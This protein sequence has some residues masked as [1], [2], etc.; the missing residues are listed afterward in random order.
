M[1]PAYASP[2]QLAGKPLTRRT[3]MWSWGVCV[4]EMIIGYCSWEAGAVAPGILEAY[5]NNM[6]DDEPAL[7]SIP[8]ALSALLTECF[9]EAEGDR[10]ASLND[11]AKT[12]Q[13]IYNN[14][15][16]AAYPRPKP[17]GGS[18]TASSLNNQAISLLD[19]EQTNEAIQIWNSALNIDPQHFETNFNLSLYQWKNDGFEETELLEKIESLLKK[20]KS[21]KEKSKKEKAKKEERSEQAE[22]IKYALATLYIQFGHY[23]QVI[24]MLNNNNKMAHLPAN[25]NND[26]CKVLGLALCA[27]Y[28]LIKNSSRWE[29]VAE[30]LKKAIADTS[31]T[32]K[33]S[34]P[35]LITAYT[36]AL[37]RSGQKKNASEFFKASTAIGIIPKQLKQAVALFLPGYEI[38]Y[39]I[40]KKTIDIVQF[41]NN[42]ENI[43]FNQA[44]SLI[45]WSMKDKQIIR[46]MKG[47][48]AKITAFCISSDEK[49]LISGSEQGDIRVWEI[50]TGEMLNVWSAHKGKINAL[51][52]SSCGQ[53]LYTASSENKLCLWDYH[54]KSRLN[55]FYGEGHS[56]EITDI[57]VS[58]FLQ[59]AG[60]IVSA[61]ADNIL[62]VWDKSSGRTNH[63]LSGHDMAITSVQWLDDKHI[64][65]GSQDKTIRLWDITTGQCQRIYKGHLGMV[66]VLRADVKQGFILSGSSDGAVRFWDITTASSYTISQFSGAVRHI[67]LDASKSFALIVTPSGISMIETSNFFRYHASYLFSLPESAVEVDQLSR[68]YQQKITLAKS[69]LNKN[70]INAMEEIQQARSIK[71]Y[72]R[73]YSAFKHW[74]KLYSFFPKLNLKDIWKHKDLKV[75]QDRIVSLDV[76]PLNDKFYSAGKDHSVYQWDIETQQLNKI[77][78]ELEKS[79][80]AIK[81]TSDGAGLLIACAENILLM[82]INSGKQLSLFSNHQADVIAMAITADGRFVLSSD[83]K[84]HF[85]LWRLLTGEVMADFTDKKNTVTTIVVTPDG[86]F[87]LTGQRNNNS[88]LIWDMTTGKC[89]SELQEHENIVT[90]IAVTSNGRYL[91]SASADA[92]LRLWQVQSSRKKSVRVMTGHT[93]RINQ[94]AIDYQGKI[95]LSVSADKSVRV[96]DIMNGEC[97]YSFENVNVSYTTAVL[98][99]DG[100]YAFSGDAQG[101]IIVWCLDWLLAK[102]TYQQ[103]DKSADIYIDNYFAT[104]KTSEPHKELSNMLRILKYAGYGWL[105]KNEAG[106]QLVNF[107][108]AHLN[109][110]LPGSKLSRSKV[111]EKQ[112]SGSRKPVLYVF[113]SA[114]VF[115]LILI[116]SITGTQSEPDLDETKSEMDLQIKITDENEQATINTMVDIAVLLSK[117]NNR[118]II[119]NGRLLQRS[120]RVPL[121][122]DELQKILR[123]NDAD[124]F[125]SWGHAFKYQGV[126]NGPL[127]G[128]IVLRSSGYDQQYK[129]DDDLL[130]NGFPHWDS[131]EIRKNNRRLL[132]LS[133]LNVTINTS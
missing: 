102:K 49:I 54:K 33:I 25:I 82:D 85:Y 27:N 32:N 117:L 76:S 84:G 133:S 4:L 7:A 61:G 95:A 69:F 14:E 70:N 121:D 129:T 75:H 111:S 112:N 92:S 119:H 45:L 47:H 9:Q 98:S 68:E 126:R 15:S 125:D 42:G 35:Y 63:I 62:R 91:L 51:Q 99:M 116:F 52:I 16:V 72:E 17:Q 19:L 109:I 43:V 97:L 89:I 110:I 38:L 90:S 8:I 10:P 53:L 67:T 66:N 55:S 128:R 28:R 56:G 77:F 40:A 3:D 78:P 106:L 123:L 26:A 59:S 120:L 74:S 107:S 81:V 39:R 87:A 50:A 96:W 6:L 58:P 118:A 131:L 65:S 113:F 12:L 48:I 21:K 108:Q 94:V 1:T 88:V 37:Q 130:L 103:W 31:F 60:Q 71:G 80:S 20:E 132:K 57:H 36:L 24:E 23:T 18:G 13:E 115:M 5:N 29:L 73:D 83:D 127:Q 11:I 22:R 101:E 79:I 44:N 86:R 34:D 104:H 41:I 93:Q 100:Q 30:C 64:L 114:A 122:I 105:D 46:E 2:E 124:L